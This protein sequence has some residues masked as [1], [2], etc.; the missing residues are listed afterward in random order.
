VSRQHDIGV[1]GGDGGI[2]D[3]AQERA[4]VGHGF[5]AVERDSIG[6]RLSI[7]FRQKKTPAN[8]TGV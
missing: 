2:E 8:A 6:C 1:C 3:R 4:V 5:T 7:Q